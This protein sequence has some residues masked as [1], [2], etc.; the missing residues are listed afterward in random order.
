MNATSI[1]TDLVEASINRYLALDPE[2]SAQLGELQGK[3]VAFNLSAPEVCI[4]AAPEA[5]KISLQSASDIVPDC[6]I[7]G[8]AL[9]LIKMM[10]SAQPT[11]LLNSGEIEITGDSRIAQ[12]FSDVLNEVEIDWEEMLSK[13]VGDF[14]AHRIGNQVTTV[15]N[16][17]SQALKS[18]RMDGTEYLQEE[19]G[20][21]PTAI[22]IAHFTE[23]TETFRSDVDRL[24]ARIK[25]LEKKLAARTDT[26]S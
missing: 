26:P 19:S 23:E 12:R 17:F 14:A 20:I 21:L 18:L 3:I 22:E 2:I 8:S 1:L 25:R 9:S 6:V 11:R 5:G 7:S 13:V 15:Q 10:R 4:Y 24:E 16:W